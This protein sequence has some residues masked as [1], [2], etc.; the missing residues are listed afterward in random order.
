MST[1]TN[2]FQY[3]QSKGT[4]LPSLSER[5]TAY[6][7]SGL[8]Q[9]SEYVGSVAQNNSLLGALTKNTG[10]GA[11]AGA[12]AGSGTGGSPSG[13]PG[14][15]GT[16]GSPSGGPAGGTGG[17]TPVTPG[18]SSADGGSAVSSSTSVR[19]AL[20]S[21]LSTP[22][23]VAGS[24]NFSSFAA[25]V[26]PAGG[27]PATPQYASTYASLRASQGIDT[28]EDNITTLQNQANAL[29][30]QLPA[31]EASAEE[32]ATSGKVFNARMSEEQRDIA[33]QLDVLNGQISVAQ[34]TLQ[35]K[36]DFIN[37]MMGYTKDDY[38]TA[39]AQYENTLS[40]NMQLLSAFNTQQ[41]KVTTSAQANLQTIATLISNSGMSLADLSPTQKT[42]IANLELAAGIPAGTYE[43]FMASKPKAT[44]LATSVQ[45]DASG[46]EFV[47]VV[48]RDPATGAISVTNIPTGGYQPPTGTATVAD[49][50]N[51]FYAGVNDLISSKATTTDG[52]PV[53]D[54]SGYIT[55]EGFKSIIQAGAESH[56]SV[57]DIIKQYG[58]QLYLPLDSNGNVSSDQASAYG[59][60]PEQ[61]KEITGS[62]TIDQ[63][64]SNSGGLWGQWF[65]GGQ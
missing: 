36:T 38:T 4:A 62:A 43:T 58:S 48:N 24:S 35:T 33:S 7:K 14:G 47:A 54:S 46:N 34:S 57:S 20:S 5:A 19:N 13:S 12:G 45:S 50:Q 1:P 52:S 59:L 53:V 39:S 15:A 2:L 55:P 21:G 16:G 11:G 44:V 61:V 26:T 22:D 31:F 63:P 28:I 51:N 42:Q 29:S 17:T 23:K 49:Q 64:Q 41:D 10:T 40:D 56:L 27:P 60:T 32:G 25:S 18:L 3:Y 9:A 30:A 37:T 65:R 8:G 6:E